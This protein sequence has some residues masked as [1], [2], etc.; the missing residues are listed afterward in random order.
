MGV[1][2]NG[3]RQLLAYADDMNLWDYKGKHRNVGS[4]KETDLEVNVEIIKYIFVSCHKEYRPKSGHDNK[5][6]IIWKCVTVQVFGN[7]SNEPKFDSGG[8]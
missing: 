6:E 8:N 3:T 7:N 4:S 1:K 5:K 2:L